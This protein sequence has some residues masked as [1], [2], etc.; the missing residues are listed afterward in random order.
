M[1]SI[2]QPIQLVVFD[3]A[4]TTVDHGSVAPLA[5]FIRAFEAHGVKVTADQARRPMGLEKLDHLRTMLESEDVRKAWQAVHQRDWTEDD[6]KSLYDRFVPLQMEVIDQHCRLTPGLLT[7]VARLREHGIKI[8]ATTGYFRAAAE[9]VYLAAAEQ[10]FTPD[11]CVCAEDVAAGR[12][13]PWM[14]FQIMQ[15][16]DVFPPASVLKIGDTVPDIAEGL[17]AG[18]WSVG[19]MRTSSEVGCT[20]TQWLELTEEE[21]TSR[22]AH[23]RHKLFAAGAHAVIETLRE[24]PTLL[25]TINA[26]IARGDRP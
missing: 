5:A 10:G 23:A 12:P 15:T 17:A 7:C 19:V 21:R 18:C 25:D 26:R 24:L 22:L 4:G 16:L 11:C 13:A 14:I 6:L 20:E 1:T 8:G 3:W 9:R 2:F